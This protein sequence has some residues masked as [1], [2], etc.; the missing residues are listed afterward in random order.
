MENLHN[1][2][3]N[4]GEDTYD[5]FHLPTGHEPKAH[6]FDELQNS[7]V[8]L[9]FKIPAA[10]QDVDDLTLCEMLTEAYREQ[11][12]YFVQEGVSVSQL[13]SSVRFDRS[14]QLDGEMVDRSG[15]PD[16]CNSS[17]AQIRTL[18]EEQRQTILADCNARVSHHELQAA[19]AEEERRLLQ[20]QLWQQKLEFREAHQRSLT[21]M[22]ELR[23]FQSSAF[24]TIARRKLIEDQ[25]TI[26]ELSG[27]VQELQNEVNC[28]ND[29]KDF[30]DAESIEESVWRNKRPRS[31]TVSFVADRLLT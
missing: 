20:G 9:S 4:G 2:A 17:K 10:D 1:S 29:S 5:V 28:M 24:D 23:K 30:Q 19:Q 21:E 11:V 3:N 16:E 25:N 26:L 18:L 31:R 12:D 15:Q 7:S 22:E 13:S 27:R 14:G 6:D 8:P